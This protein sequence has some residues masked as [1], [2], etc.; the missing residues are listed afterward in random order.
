[1]CSL[2]SRRPPGSTRNATL[3]PYTALFRSVSLRVRR[4][5]CAAAARG[6][7]AGWRR[8]RRLTRR[9]QAGAALPAEPPLR[10]LNCKEQKCRTWNIRP[11]SSPPPV[12]GPA[13]PP[14]RRPLANAPTPCQLPPRPPPP[15]P[16]AP[17]QLPPPPPPPPRPP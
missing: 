8:L 13:P 15:P 7:V 6:S 9:P 3:F 1:M 11:P 14:P 5:R 16:P 12:T 10:T 17:P 2:T 4:N